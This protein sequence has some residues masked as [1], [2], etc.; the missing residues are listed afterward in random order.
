[1][2][3]A[4]L[5][6]RAGCGISVTAT[7]GRREL[8]VPENLHSE[9][10][11]SSRPPLRN[12]SILRRKSPRPD[13]GFWDALCNA[14]RWPRTRCAVDR[15][16]PSRRAASRTGSPRTESTA[17]RE[18]W[19]GGRPS[20]RPSRLTRAS[21]ARTRS[22]ILA[23]SNSE[24]APRMCIWSF[25][26]GVVA[27]GG[28]DDPAA[29]PP[30]LPPDAGQSGSHPFGDSSP[31]EFRDRPE[32]VHLELP[33]W[34][35]RINALRQRDEVH[36]QCLQIVEQCDEVLETAAESVEPP[37]YDD[38]EAPLLAWAEIARLCG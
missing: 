33:G 30:P 8:G 34:R 10:P 29:E 37:T 5:Y 16:T 23:R 7:S 2:G 6:R 15:D 22:A 20:R 19:R 24:I 27:P 4:G 13:Q 28:V 38:I 26:A 11:A 35:R 17:C 12:P 21:P 25:P 36:A 14:G 1:M 3:E 32:D 18:T 31:L 9:T